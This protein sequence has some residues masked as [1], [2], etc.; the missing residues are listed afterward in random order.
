MQLP[1]TQNFSCHV[2]FMVKH[3]T[4]IFTV[5]TSRMKVIQKFRVF[6]AMLQ[7]IYATILSEIDKAPCQIVYHMYSQGNSRPPCGK[8]WPR[9][10]T[11]VPVGHQSG[12]KDTTMPQ[13]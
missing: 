10:I 7:R 13:Y 11:V 2:Y 12:L 3:G 5:E 6:C 9:I 1:Y 8:S 4:R